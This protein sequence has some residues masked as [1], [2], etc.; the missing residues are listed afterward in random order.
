MSIGVGPFPLLPWLWELF[1]GVPGSNGMSEH[2]RS[3]VQQNSK[4]RTLSVVIEGDCQLD[5]PGEGEKGELPQC[6]Y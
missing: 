6:Q 2:L 1:C 3:K 5:T 4:Q